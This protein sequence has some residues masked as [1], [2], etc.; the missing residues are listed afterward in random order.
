[1]TIKEVENLAELARIELSQKEKESI[2]ADMEGILGY[3]KRIENIKGSK[4]SKEYE[5]ENVWR[6]DI[7]DNRE[8]SK[9]I[10]TKEFPNSQ[11]GYLKVKK[12]L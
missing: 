2:L 9:E 12:I 11:D 4:E 8:Y 1:M 10:I 6:A 3:I 7:A 5:L